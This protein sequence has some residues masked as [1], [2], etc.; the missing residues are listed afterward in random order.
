MLSR[1][2]TG[3]VLNDIPYLVS[4][5]HTCQVDD[6]PSSFIAQHWKLGILLYSNFCSPS[7]LQLGLPMFLELGTQ[8]PFRTSR[9]VNVYPAGARE[10]IACLSVRQVDGR[11]ILDLTLSSP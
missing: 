4:T 8:I 7:A 11:K 9:Q 2:E 6:P 5:F 1:A 3:H 10:T